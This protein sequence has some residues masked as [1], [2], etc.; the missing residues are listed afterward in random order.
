M[1]RKSLPASFS[2]GVS[3]PSSQPPS[4]ELDSLSDIPSDADNTTRIIDQLDSQLS[5]FPKDNEESISSPPILHK[6][7]NESERVAKNRSPGTRM[8]ASDSDPN[9]TG[10]PPPVTNEE[11]CAEDEQ[12]LDDDM[13]WGERFTDMIAQVSLCYFCLD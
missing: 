3:E 6:V 8:S 4:N 10:P 2:H 9:L 7:V 13:I 11:V 12:G 1:V 5:L